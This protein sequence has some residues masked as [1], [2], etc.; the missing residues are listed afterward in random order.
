MAQGKEWNKDEVMK[1]LEPFFK[2]GCSVKKACDYAG[3]PR[4]TVQTWIDADDEL[5]LQITAW[6]NEMSVLA[7]KNWRKALEAK[8]K[9]ASGY[10]ASV[11][12]LA[13][14]EKDEFSERKEITGRDGESLFED[15]HKEK[16]DKAVKGFL[17][18]RGDI[19]EGG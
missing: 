10:T 9:G 12:W 13:K 11:D 19:G 15:E 2:L 8:K 4:T 6:Q 3:I 17:A 18:D 14:K 7:R 16:S 1:T 5:R